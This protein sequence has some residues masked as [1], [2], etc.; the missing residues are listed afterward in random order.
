MPTAKRKRRANVTVA[1]RTWR[2][3]PQ[4][5]QM[6]HL[7]L[8]DR[9]PWARVTPHHL[10]RWR[11]ARLSGWLAAPR[12]RCC[13]LG[14]SRRGSQRACVHEC[15]CG[16]ARVS[17]EAKSSLEPLKNLGHPPPPPATRP[18]LVFPVGKSEPN[19]D[20]ASHGTC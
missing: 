3:L 2:A 5:S 20:A 11:P 13:E 15:V 8:A 19:F 6:P 9:R 14:H 16:L 18:S 12:P 4:A 7:P 1:V 10:D 17:R